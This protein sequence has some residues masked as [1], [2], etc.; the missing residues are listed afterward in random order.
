VYFSKIHAEATTVCQVDTA[1]V[2]V[3]PKFGEATHWRND[4]PKQIP[5]A[6]CKKKLC[7]TETSCSAGA[8]MVEGCIAGKEEQR[9]QHSYSIHYPNVPVP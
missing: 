2:E 6:I 4:Y 9:K 7:A 8:T 3:C 5:H 1:A